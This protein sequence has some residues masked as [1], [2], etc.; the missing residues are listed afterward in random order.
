MLAAQPNH[1]DAKHLLG[2]LRFQQG[3]NRLRRAQP[4]LRALGIE[5]AFSREGQSGNRVIRI[6]MGA[7]NTVSTVST[8]SSVR[9]NDGPCQPAAGAAGD[10]RHRA[11]AT[12]AADADGADGADAKSAVH[13]G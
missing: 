5:V 8:V 1:F 13:F 3:R 2:V 7:E 6:R 10:E 4:F 12:A 9:H 11:A